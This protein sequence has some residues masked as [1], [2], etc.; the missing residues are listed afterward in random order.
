MAIYRC[1][2]TDNMV[3]DDWDPGTEYGDGLICEE[4]VEQV[5]C[6]V[7]EAIGSAAYESMSDEEILAYHLRN[8]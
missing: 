6:E 1:E 4:A 5:H 7:E 8:L 3:D 2:I